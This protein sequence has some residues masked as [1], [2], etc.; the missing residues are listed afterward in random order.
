MDRIRYL[1]LNS[2]YT[3]SSKISVALTIVVIM[4]VAFGAFIFVL[5]ID[6]T[7]LVKKLPNAKHDDIVITTSLVGT[8]QGIASALYFDQK[9]DS[10]E[11]PTVLV[12][13][14][15]LTPSRDTHENLPMLFVTPNFGKLFEV[16]MHLGRF[17]DARE[18]VGFVKTNAVISYKTWVNKFN[19][20]PNILDREFFLYDKYYRVIGVIDKNF[21]EPE[22]HNSGEPGA[23][24]MPL[25]SL[26]NFEDNLEKWAFNLDGDIYY[27]GVKKPNASLEAI[28]DR[29]EHYLEELADKNIVAR[30]VVVPDMK[31]KLLRHHIKERV[32]LLLILINVGIWGVIFIALIYTISVLIN[33]GIERQNVLAVHS[34]VGAKKSH[35]RW[36]L[37]TDIA[38]L[39]VVAVVFGY[40][41]GNFFIELVRNHLA[42]IIPR[43]HELHVTF[44]SVLVLL[45]IAITIA[46]AFS[47]ICIRFH[48]SR[49]LI[50]HLAGSGKG[51]LKSHP[52]LY[53]KSL[54]TFQMAL[55]L[56]LIIFNALALKGSIV[57]L[58]D[59][60]PM[61]RDDVYVVLLIPPEGGEWPSH[62]VTERALTDIE[63]ALMARGNVEMLS[64]SDPPFW[65]GG[66][67]SVYHP[68][69][70]KKYDVLAKSIDV[71]NLKITGKEFIAG[72]MFET[73]D[74]D[75]YYVLVNKQFADVLGNDGIDVVG[76]E[77]HYNHNLTITGV[78]TDSSYEGENF[79]IYY[80]RPS[81]A[82]MFLID[83][84]TPGAN[85]TAVLL[86]IVKR[87][88]DKY[89][90]GWHKP[91]SYF[92]RK[93]LKQD[94][95]RSLLSGFISISILIF[96]VVGLFNVIQYQVILR[97]VEFKVRLSVGAT[98]K[99]IYIILLK[100]FSGP[101]IIGILCTFLVYLIFSDTQIFSS[102]TTIYSLLI[103]SV[104]ITLLFMLTVYFAVVENVKRMHGD[105]Y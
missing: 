8:V 84:S 41:A 66:H 60:A 94:T 20:D 5:A 12:Y 31:F 61:H 81:W 64:R 86:D 78:V 7:L 77:L 100:Y 35:I 22:I 29:F 14:K 11:N 69:T 75:N 103:S 34:V 92:S 65:V 88:T 101:Y 4:G 9:Q 74:D 99:D 47:V 21:V 33:H 51:V 49:E 16:P 83:Y 59:H 28:G 58:I 53:L 45:I 1:L 48:R 52:G 13:K 36:L 95:S 105:I 90:V 39:M 42:P 71:N 50:E 73:K 40:I 93:H 85:Q 97:G 43:S 18:D 79:V 38:L 102:K 68:K 2:L 55:S 67:W 89:V 17:F 62:V 91:L 87:V 37:V 82:S 72:E 10:L 44:T 6:H 54:L 63:K 25:H 23:I 80:E 104:F 57:S 98:L 27:I 3:W 70:N 15:A 76:G 96:T 26:N 46:F 30:Q 24:W 32:S 56:V 19:K